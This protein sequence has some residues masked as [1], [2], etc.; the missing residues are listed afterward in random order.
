M[1]SPGKR[2]TAASIPTITV[3]RDQL[4]YGDS[5]SKRCDVFYDDIRVFRKKYRSSTGLS[6]D[7]LHNWKSPEHQAALTEMSRAFLDTDGNGSRYWP[8][9][10]GS[11]N[12]NKLQYSRHR[13]R[14]VRRRSHHTALC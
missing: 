12:R 10:D 2:V 5:Q 1:S 7:D 13:G 11:S 9:D 4:D 3:L 6:G 8:D 14:F